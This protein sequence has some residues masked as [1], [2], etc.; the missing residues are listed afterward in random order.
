MVWKRLEIENYLLTKEIIK[1]LKQ[2]N[3]YNLTQLPE[4]LDNVKDFANDD[5]KSII[6]SKYKEPGFDEKKLN[7][8]IDNMRPEEISEDIKTLY[9]FIVSK[10]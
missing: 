7:E 5:V 9:D 3:Y 4:N 10:L 2:Y 8:L 6:Q 1:E